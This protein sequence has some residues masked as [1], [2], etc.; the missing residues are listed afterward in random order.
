MSLVKSSEMISLHKISKS[1]VL[2]NN[3]HA[4]LKNISLQINKGELVAIMGASGSGKSSLLNILGLLDSPS[5][6]IYSLATQNTLH[7]TE[8]ERAYFRNKYI[9]FIFQQFNLLGR[10]SVEQNINLPLLYSKNPKTLSNINIL[11]ERVGMLSYKK[12]FPNQL[13]GGQ[14]QRVAIARALINNPEIILADEPTG[15]LDSKTGKE[16]IDLFLTLNE[17]GKTIIIVTHDEN[18][19]KVCKRQILIQDGEI[20][21]QN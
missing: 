13:S 15:A 11:L 2:G 12:H 6:G 1:F 21:R 20:F 9:G 16:I 14:Q 4:V 18:V 10:F 8:D 7:L 17:D 3:L 19:A 5:S